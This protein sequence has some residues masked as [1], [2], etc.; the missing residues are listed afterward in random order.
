MTNK[1]IATFILSWIILYIVK[2]VSKVIY[3]YYITFGTNKN[4]KRLQIINRTYV[5][6]NEFVFFNHSLLP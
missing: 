2:L 3:F 1:I 6:L 5:H 4:I